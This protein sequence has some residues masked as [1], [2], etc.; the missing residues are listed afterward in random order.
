MAG[1]LGAILGEGAKGVVE[2]IGSVL[3]NV[4]TS[5]EERLDKQAILA[6]IG[7]RPQLAQVELNKIEASHRSLFVAGWRPFIG[8]VCG[9]GIAYGFIARDLIAWVLAIQ[10]STV[11]PPPELALEHLMALV[12]SLLGLGAFR[13]VEKLQ[14]RSK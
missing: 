12:V 9:F 8:W 13:S 5:D 2:G 11:E 3:D 6:R 10:G 7:Q 4:F 14:G 1:I